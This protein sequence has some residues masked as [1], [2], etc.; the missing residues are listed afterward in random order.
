MKGALALWESPE[1]WLREM[2]LGREFPRT[3]SRAPWPLTENSMVS[4][5][6]RV[7]LRLGL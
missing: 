3:L 7:L 1:P 4:S 6:L 5:S 2:S